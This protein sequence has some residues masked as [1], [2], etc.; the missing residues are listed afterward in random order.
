MRQRILILELGRCSG[1]M[2]GLAGRLQRGPSGQP[3]RQPDPDGARFCIRTGTPALMQKEP[4]FLAK[5]GPEMGAASS[6]VSTLA[7]SDWP[8]IYRA[9]A[10]SLRRQ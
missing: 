8:S 6:I 1:K 4:A 3:P 9:S 2:S 7:M 10:V 5:T